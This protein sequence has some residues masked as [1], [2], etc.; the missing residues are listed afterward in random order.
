MIELLA[1]VEKSLYNL[2][3][4]TD[5]WH[6]L[7]VDYEPPRVERLWCDWHRAGVTYRINLHRIH[8][9]EKALMHP[10]PWPS[11]VKVLSGK[12]EMGIGAL[13]VAGPASFPAR[14]IPEVMKTVATVVLTAGATYEMLDER[15]WHY[16]KPIDKPSLSLMLTGPPFE[17]RPDHGPFKK[18][19]KKLGPLSPEAE[20]ALLNEFKQLYD[21]EELAWPLGNALPRGV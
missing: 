10:H 15:G 16:V 3:R 14:A 4:Q 9:C 18:P 2:L 11:A 7:D 12:Y 5:V 8:P 1:E 6:T 20:A 17:W 21:N 13:L 19:D